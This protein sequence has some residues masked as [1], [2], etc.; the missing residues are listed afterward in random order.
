MIWRYFDFFSLISIVFYRRSSSIAQSLLNRHAKSSTKV[1]KNTANSMV[2]AAKSKFGQYVA[3]SVSDHDDDPLVFWRRYR[4]TDADTTT[5]ALA[6]LGAATSSSSVEI[7]NGQV[8]RMIS[9]SRTSLL[10]RLL[11]CVKSSSE[12]VVAL[13]WT[14]LR[15]SANSMLQAT[16]QNPPKFRRIYPPVKDIMMSRRRTLRRL[17]FGHQ[18]TWTKMLHSG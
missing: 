15:R 2:A 8:G 16:C 17:I 18:Q 1:P 12:I 13:T 5:A 7:D 11:T 4:E 6:V 3:L 9:P 14:K 10:R